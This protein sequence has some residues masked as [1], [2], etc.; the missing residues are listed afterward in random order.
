MIKPHEVYDETEY[1]PNTNLRLL[2]IRMSSSLTF[3]K[4]LW[5]HASYD[6]LYAVLI[7]GASFYK[8]RIREKDNLTIVVCALNCLW[9]V[10]EYVRISFGYTG[11]IMETFPELIA[12]LIFSLFFTLP[13]SALPLFQNHLFPHETCTILI[14]LVFLTAEL[15]IGFYVMQRFMRT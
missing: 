9:A 3:Q 2:D 7:L 14:N 5:F 4:L 12:F 13:L 11:N 8:V 1:I 15:G 6:L 10:L